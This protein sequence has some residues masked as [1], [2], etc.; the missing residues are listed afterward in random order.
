MGLDFSKTAVQS[1]VMTNTANTK[2]KSRLSRSM[3]L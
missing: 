3:I 1:T 2:M